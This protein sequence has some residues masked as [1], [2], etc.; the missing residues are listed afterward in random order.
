MPGWK[1]VRISQ[2]TTQ[3]LRTLTEEARPE[4]MGGKGGFSISIRGVNPQTGYMISD[5]GSEKTH[6]FNPI[7]P[8][9]SVPDLRAFIKLNSQFLKPADKYFGGWLTKAGDLA[10]DVSSNIECEH[11]KH[12]PCEHRWNAYLAMIKNKQDAI[13]DLNGG[14]ELSATEGKSE[15]PNY[16]ELF[17]QHERDMARYRG[18]AQAKLAA[19]EASGPGK[20]YFRIGPDA[21]D[22]ELLEIIN[23][24]AGK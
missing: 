8:H 22:E 12:E 4:S 3:I 10:L 23:K 15:Y 1:T 7:R 9:L 5:A 24:I 17:E 20:H 18:Q 14:R 2:L 13:Y 6:P 19:Q 16:T 11:G 21:T